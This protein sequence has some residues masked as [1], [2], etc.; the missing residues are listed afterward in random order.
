MM[1]KKLCRETSPLN[2]VGKMENKKNSIRKGERFQNPTKQK[3]S[4]YFS[5]YN[6]FSD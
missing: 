1:K 6:K 3:S 4:Y 2:A 5:F